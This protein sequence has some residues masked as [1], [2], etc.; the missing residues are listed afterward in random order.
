MGP[1]EREECPVPDFDQRTRRRLV[2]IGT[3]HENSLLDLDEE[4][5]V[6]LDFEAAG[7]VLDLEEEGPVDLDAAGPVPEEDGLVVPEEAGPLPEEDG[8]VVPELWSNIRC[9]ISTCTHI[10]VKKKKKE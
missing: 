8:L 6:L 2:E 7:P 5:P 9:A 1:E 3:N 4:G 10:E